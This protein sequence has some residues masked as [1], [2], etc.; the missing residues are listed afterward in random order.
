MEPELVKMKCPD[1]GR[2]LY[3]EKISM[4][5]SFT[6]T[7]SVCGNLL[8][9]DNEE[10][11]NFHKHLHSKDSRWPIDGKDTGYVEID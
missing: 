4:P 5:T 8:I 11:K 6:T 9:Y 10:L 7:C 3:F 1:C 2:N